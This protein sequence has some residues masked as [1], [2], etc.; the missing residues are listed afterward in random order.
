MLLRLGGGLGR[1]CGLCDGVAVL[2]VG[3]FGVSGALDIGV[4]E[5]ECVHGLGGIDISIYVFGD[6]VGE[7]L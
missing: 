4:L 2:A 6:E 5:W 1:L 7:L 3:S